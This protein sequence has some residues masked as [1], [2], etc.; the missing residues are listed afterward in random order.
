VRPEWLVDCPMPVLR[1]SAIG[2]L[3]E[4]LLGP[5]EP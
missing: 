4:S 3:L 1:M 5:C 2:N